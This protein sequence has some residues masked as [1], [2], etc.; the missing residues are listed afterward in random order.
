MLASKTKTNDV[1]HGYLA[2]SWDANYVE[3]KA[4]DC[5]YVVEDGNIFVVEKI[6]Q[7]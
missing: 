3:V 7:T 2:C 6:G 1:A 5:G 4:F